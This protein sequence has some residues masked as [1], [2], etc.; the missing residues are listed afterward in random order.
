MAAGVLLVLLL[1]ALIVVAV[2]GVMRR[3]AR[4][5]AAATAPR[6]L[7]L[8]D[9]G[10]GDIVQHDVIDWVVE[11]RL[12]YRQGDFVWLEYLLRD[13]ERSIWLVVNEDDN[14]VVTLEQ[15]IDLPMSLDARPPAQIEVE[16]RLYRL[17]ERGF[18]V[19][20]AQQRRFNIDVGSCHFFDYRSGPTAVLSIELWGSTEAGAGELE[21]TAGERISPRSLSLLPGDGRSV[22]RPS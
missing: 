13:D 12:V 7:T 3:S 17:I 5:R 15:P 11:D 21:V 2:V 9:L 1:I 8:F 22:Y 6:E 4:S 16:G 14:L 10:V 20:T 19:V 18:A